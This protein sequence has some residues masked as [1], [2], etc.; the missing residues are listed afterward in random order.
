MTEGVVN[1]A[2]WRAFFD[3]SG[4]ILDEYRF[5]KDLFLKVC[6]LS[7]SRITISFFPRVIERLQSVNNMNFTGAYDLWPNFFLVFPR[8]VNSYVR[9]SEFDSI[10]MLRS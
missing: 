7:R 1:E 6:C 9:G 4:R 8:E 3:E 10:G 2:S 5:R